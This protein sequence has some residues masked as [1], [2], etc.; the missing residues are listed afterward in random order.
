[1]I[2]VVNLPCYLTTT[3]KQKTANSCNGAE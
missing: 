1:M 2:L 3:V